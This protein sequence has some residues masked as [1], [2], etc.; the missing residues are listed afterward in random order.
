MSAGSLFFSAAKDQRIEIHLEEATLWPEGKQPT[1]AWVAILSPRVLQI[2]AHR[3]GLDF[4]YH[5]EFR[6]LPEGETYRIYLDA[7]SEPQSPAEVGSG[8][9]KTGI[10]SKVIYFIVGAGAGAGSAWVVHTAV[11]GSN[12][13]SPAKP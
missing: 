5:Q 12:P 1:Q 11:S 10:A 9:R 3:G 6:N 4:T 13:I 7:P 8:G 2:T